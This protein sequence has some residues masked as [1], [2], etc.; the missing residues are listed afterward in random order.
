MNPKLSEGV[1]T[2]E[3]ADRWKPVD[4]A[5]LYDVAGWGQRYFSVGDNGHLWVHPTKDPNRGIDLKKLIA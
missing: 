4:A 1:V 2:R 5:E 3:P